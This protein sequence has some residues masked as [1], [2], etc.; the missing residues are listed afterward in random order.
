MLASTGTIVITAIILVVLV[1]LFIAVLQ[2][3]RRS[4]R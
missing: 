2:R 3:A 1:I 4:G